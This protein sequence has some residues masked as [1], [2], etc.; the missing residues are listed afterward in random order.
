[1]THF[2]ATTL[3]LLAG[4]GIAT[5]QEDAGDVRRK[6]EKQMEEITRLMRDSERHLL[7]LTRVDRVA[8][9]QAGIVER[10]KKLL[11]EPPPPDGDAAAAREQKKQE[12]ERE[13]AEIQRRIQ[14]LME[15][16]KRL[17]ELSAEQLRKLLRELP[18]QNS[19]NPQGGGDEKKNGGGKEP[20]DRE[21]QKEQG[22]QE[23]RQEPDRSREK[24]PDRPR[25]ENEK[26]ESKPR[27][28][29]EQARRLRRVEAW[30]AHLPP[31]EQARISRNDF[32]NI[33]RRYRKLVQEYTALR[34]KREAERDRDEEDR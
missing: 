21:K 19:P 3:L 8:T 25:L 2:V 6:L 22:E 4:A 31:E 15:N 7:E 18:R 10:L 23:Q 1:M 32:S 5:A 17:G 28:E 34:A 30:I 11:D 26:N 14:A 13:Q 29:S 33:P 16:Q 24:Q 20:K 12:L 9:E 27:D